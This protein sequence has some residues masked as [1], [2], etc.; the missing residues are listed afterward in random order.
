MLWDII[1]SLK[2]NIL[3]AL[4]WAILILQWHLRKCQLEEAKQQPASVP[5]VVELM[6]SNS[7]CTKE[8]CN[9]GHG[10]SA[11][12][13]IGTVEKTVGASQLHSDVS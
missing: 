11:A 12:I 1:Q 13:K 8:G 10:L 9:W 6:S 4:G 2:E 7:H 5:S 3:K